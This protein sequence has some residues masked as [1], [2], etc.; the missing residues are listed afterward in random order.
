MDKKQEKILELAR[1]FIDAP[2]KYGAKPEDIPQYFD[3]SSFTQYIYK[4]INVQLERSTIL[5]ATQGQEILDIKNAK[6]GDLLFFRG[7]KGH[8][9]DE[10]FPERKIYIGHVAIYSENHKAIH[11]A[12]PKGVIEENINEIIKIRDPIVM[13]KRIL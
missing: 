10:L 8:Y 5:Q 7:S 9:N 4:Q 6:T 13:I 11:S 3:C 1:S 2:Y 12:S